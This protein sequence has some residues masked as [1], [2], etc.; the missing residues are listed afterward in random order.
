MGKKLNIFNK[1]NSLNSEYLQIVD[2]VSV[3]MKYMILKKLRIE[4]YKNFVKYYSY[5]EE[6]VYYKIILC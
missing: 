2:N 6:R 4:T 1:L 3:T 5:T